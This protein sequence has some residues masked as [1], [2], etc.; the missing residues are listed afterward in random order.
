VLDLC[1]GIGRHSIGLA[2]KGHSVTGLDFNSDYVKRAEGLSLP[3]RI[4]PNF[5]QADMRKIPFANKFD[6]VY[7]FWSSFGY[8]DADTNLGILKGL[9][10]AMKPGGRFLLDIINRDFV[11][12]HF[13]PRDWT[14]TGRGY[15]MEKRVYHT[16]TSRMLTTWYFAGDGHII[17]KQSDIRLYGLP[18]IEALLASAGFRVTARFGDANQAS[19]GFDAPRL[20]IASSSP[21][22]Q[23]K[24]PPSRMQGGRNNRRWG[25]P[26]ARAGETGRGRG[27][28]RFNR[29]MGERVKGR[30]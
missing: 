1:C 8:Y 2:K 3:L 21:G 7:C 29:R 6:A 5:M 16:D 13:Q 9:I 24:P 14:K 15:I 28:E 19:I 27:G 26:Q 25:K 12:R 18:E 4:R 23:L 20:I 22:E 11:L 10:K 30:F 17:R